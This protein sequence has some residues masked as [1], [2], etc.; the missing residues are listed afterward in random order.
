MAQVDEIL[1][2]GKKGFV[3]PAKEKKRFTDGL[4]MQGTRASATPVLT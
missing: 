1:P 4:A 2:C 3:Y